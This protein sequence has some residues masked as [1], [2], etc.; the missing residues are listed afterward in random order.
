MRSTWNLSVLLVC[1]WS[2]AACAYED[3]TDLSTTESTLAGE[4]LNGRSLNGRSLNGSNLGNAVQWASFDKVKLDKKKLLWVWLDGSELVGLRKDW[5]LVRGDDFEGAQFHARSDT[6]MNVA[7]RVAEVIVPGAGSDVWQYAVEFRYQGD[8][9]PMCLADAITGE[10]LNGPLL[11]GDSLNE[12]VANGEVV[13]LPTVP[14]DGYW[15]YQE[16]VAGGGSKVA[17]WER[18]TFAC[19]QIGAIGKC[20]DAGYQ[21]WDVAEDGT[22][23]ATAHEACVRLIRADYCGDGTAHTVEGNW[24]NVYDLAGVQEDSE[25]W[26]AEAEWNADGARCVTTHL[27]AVEPVACAD[28]LFDPTCGDPADWAG[29]TLLV[30]ETP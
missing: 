21:P 16:G 9:F 3:A 1:S 2:F 30:S 5:H 18:F 25:S 8:W 24:V 28:E 15:N 22:P 20:V 14:V 17:N 7:L 4:A 29:G 12:A 19:R 13:V 26:P 11:N 27:R 23:L 6:G 10:G